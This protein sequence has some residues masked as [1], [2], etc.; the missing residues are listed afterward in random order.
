MGVELALIEPLPRLEITGTP[1]TMGGKGE[2]R[3][4]HRAPWFGEDPCHQ[5]DSEGRYCDA[6]PHAR[7]PATGS[8]MGAVPPV[9]VVPSI[10]TQNPEKQ[11]RVHRQ[12]LAGWGEK[13]RAEIKY[14]SHCAVIA[15]P[16]SPEP[17]RLT[18][19]VV[20]LGPVMGWFPARSLSQV[21]GPMPYGPTPPLPA[22]LWAA[23]TP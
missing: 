13:P 1:T 17:D 8:D 18:R 10:W 11:A 21:L 2:N 14:S 6:A 3:H 9:A 19:Q 20:K 22:Q 16:W 12:C 23:S 7:L 5:G 15:L 4:G